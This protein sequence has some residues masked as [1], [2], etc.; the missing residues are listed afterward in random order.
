MSRSPD[1]LARLDAIAASVAAHGDAQ[2]LIGLGSVGQD[3]ARLD[4]WSDLDFFLIVDPGAKARYLDDLGWLAAAHPLAW[5]FRNTGDGHK[6]LMADGVFCEFAVFE[7]AELADIPFAPGR[8]VWARAGVDPAIALPRR[9]LPRPTT[10]ETWVVGEALSCLLV[11]LQRWHRGERLS[12]L[13][14]VQGHA[15]DRLIELDALRSRPP[16]GDPFNGERRLE[17]RQPALA[18]ELPA[19]APGYDATPAAARAMLAA[20][21]RRGAVLNDA[22]VARIKALAS[23]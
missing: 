10:D 18:A 8:L 6:A 13:R 7:P 9:P 15:L 22:V 2:A 11:G 3:T 16:A 12:A 4:A 19:L 14:L 20:L 1:L 17:A 21:R 5:S 23:G